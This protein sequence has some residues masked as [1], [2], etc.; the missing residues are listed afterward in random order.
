MGWPAKLMIDTNAKLCYG[1]RYAVYDHG[2]WIVY[3][4]IGNKI[5]QLIATSFGDDADR[6]L[7]GK[8]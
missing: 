8:E 2:S 4:K 5:R 7:R 1:N 6:V 3:E